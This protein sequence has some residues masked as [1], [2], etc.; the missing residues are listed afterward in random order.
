L[1][2]KIKIRSNCQVNIK[3][4]ILDTQNNENDILHDNIGQTIEK[5]IFKMTD[6]GHLGF[7]PIMSILESDTPHILLGLLNLQRRQNN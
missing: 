2:L 1:D 4:E 5:R 6:G 7:L 3:F